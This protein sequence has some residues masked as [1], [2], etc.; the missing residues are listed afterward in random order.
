MVGR[1][2]TERVIVFNL[3]GGLGTGMMTTASG[4]L[5]VTVVHND[6]EFLVDIRSDSEV[7]LSQAHIVGALISTLSFCLRTGIQGNSDALRCGIGEAGDGLL[8]AVVLHRIVIA[9]DGDSGRLGDGGDF[10]PT[11]DDDDINVSVVRRS[12]GEVICGQAHIILAYLSVL[13]SILTSSIQNHID[14]LIANISGVAC[15]RLLGTVVHHSLGITGNSDSD[16]IGDRGNFKITIIYHNLDVAVICGSNG[17]AIRRQAHIIRV[18]V[19]ALG[20]CLGTLFQSDADSLAVNIGGV[21]GDG[22][23]RSV[24][25]LCISVTVDGNSDFVGDGGDFK[26]TVIDD[27]FDIGVSG[28]GDSE[29]LRSQTHPIGADVGALS[30]ALARFFQ[31]NSDILLTDI[32]G[33]AGDGLLGTVVDLSVAVTSDGNDDFLI[34]R[35]LLPLC[36]EVIAAV[37]IRTS[38]F[39]FF[40]LDLL[41]TRVGAPADELIA[42]VLR[43]TERF[44]IGNGEFAVVGHGVGCIRGIRTKIAVIGDSDRCGLIAVN[45]V[46]G[47]VAGDL[48]AAVGVILNCCAAFSCP[49]EEDLVGRGGRTG[50]NS[51][52]CTLG[53]EF[54]VGDRAATFGNIRH[55]VTSLIA[56][57]GIEIN[58]LSDLSVEVERCAVFISP[59]EEGIAVSERDFVSGHRVFADRAAQRNILESLECGCLVDIIHRHRKGGSFPLGI[60]GDVVC[61]H[62]LGEVISRTLA[63]LIVKPTVEDIAVLACGSS[64]RVA[65]GANILLI[66]LAFSFFG[67]AIDEDD[68]VAVASVVEISTVIL[69]AVLGT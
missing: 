55:A 20:F 64:G 14:S 34:N 56:D 5:K 2:Q 69:I 23:L 36:I 27:N 52:R 40:E 50:K 18:N 47:H 66:F 44:I 35:S 68:V 28:R 17:K 6:L 38:R 60:K 24:V 33:E 67:S 32:G 4:D 29:A 41:L 54:V 57:A 37:R 3:H 10:K 25:D 48:D 26:L 9:G 61:R 42:V 8:A 11:I 63:Q 1:V 45:G 19:G 13:G 49:A 15:D 30:S 22:L 46:K 12:D 31:R 21:A 58:I 65:Y 59:A 43:E 51:C 16:F 7:I 53:I 39:A 62:G